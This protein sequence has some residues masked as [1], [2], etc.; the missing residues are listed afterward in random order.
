MA[1]L[2]VKGVENALM[3]VH[4][5]IS[6]AARALGVNRRSLSFRIQKNPQLREVLTDARESMLD[7]AE[8]ALQKAV[9]AGEAWAVCFYLKTQGKARGYIE[10]QEH[11]M[12]GQIILKIEADD[13]FYNNAERLAENTGNRLASPAPDAPPAPG[14]E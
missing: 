12:D 3:Q 6:A 9:L 4:G 8:T 14:T 7:N 10:R 1:K 5:N 2:T 11:Q 13:D